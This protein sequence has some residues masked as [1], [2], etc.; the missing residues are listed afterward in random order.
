M[1]YLMFQK[2]NEK[3][4]YEVSDFFKIF[5][6]STRLKLLCVLDNNALTVTEICEALSMTKSAVSH[7]LK[8]LKTNKLVK[9]KKSGKNVVYS[10]D[11]DHVSIIIETAIKHLK[12]K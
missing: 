5:G 3:D 4:I 11:D 8:I 6:D 1:G 10:L 2:I 7:Q 9:Y 12:E